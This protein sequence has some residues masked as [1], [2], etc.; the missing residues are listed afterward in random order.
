M[1]T[2]RE[3]AYVEV[4]YDPVDFIAHKHRPKWRRDSKA[5]VCEVETHSPAHDETY[6]V[7]PAPASLMFI[8]FAGPKLLQETK[9]PPN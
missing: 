5:E 9:T 2:C 7:C 3:F 6:D 4:T 8:R 1:R